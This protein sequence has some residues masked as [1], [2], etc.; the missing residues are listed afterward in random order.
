MTLTTQNNSLENS[1]SSLHQLIIIIIIQQYS[2]E[3]SYLKTCNYSRCNP[4]TS[5]KQMN[6]NKKTEKSP[7]KLGML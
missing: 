2:M 3:C 4:N 5:F 7:D 1:S 6:E